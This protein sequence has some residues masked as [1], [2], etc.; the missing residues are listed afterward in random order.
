MQFNQSR[1]DSHNLLQIINQQ[2]RKI[3]LR[4]GKEIQN[5]KVFHT[6]TM[7]PRSNKE[8]RL[9]IPG[10]RPYN[11]IIL[12]VSSCEKLMKICMYQ[13]T[14]S[15]IAKITI[16]KC[17]KCRLLTGS[18]QLKRIFCCGPMI[19]KSIINIQNKQFLSLTTRVSKFDL[20][21]MTNQLIS[22]FYQKIL[23]ST[24]TMCSRKLLF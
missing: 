24:P 19:K 9:S 16:C 1:R 23:I 21:D 18:H 5:R 7:K 4:R 12:C 2:H 22:H 15:Q 11:D 8:T 20:H 13:F 3:I 14:V 10:C 6:F 17:V